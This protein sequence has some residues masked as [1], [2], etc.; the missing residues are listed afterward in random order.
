MAIGTDNAVASGSGMNENS[1]NSVDNDN[2]SNQRR[3]THT[4]RNASN[5]QLAQGDGDGGNDNSDGNGN[6]NGNDDGDGDG[7]DNN[8]DYPYATPNLTPELIAADRDV[9]FSVLVDLSRYNVRE[10]TH[11]QIMDVLALSHS[12][13]RRRLLLRTFQGEIFDDGHVAEQVVRFDGYIPLLTMT[14]VSEEYEADL[15]YRSLE[16]WLGTMMD[17][18]GQG[19][20]IRVPWAAGAWEMRWLR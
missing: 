19:I 15:L 2:G 14:L 3:N 18:T 6:D 10:H 20:E 13:I 17:L 1:N 4:D 5:N 9:H 7:D 12:E 11:D 8:N 16:Q